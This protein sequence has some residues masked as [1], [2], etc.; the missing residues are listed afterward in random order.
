[1]R[2]SLPL[3][4]LALAVLQGCATTP[5]AAEGFWVS[6]TA[7][8]GVEADMPDSLEGLGEKADLV[9]TGRIV[10]YAEGRDYTDPGR[11][12]NR[13]GNVV[14]EIAKSHPSTAAASGRVR[15]EFTRAP[16]V[17]AA[18]ASAQLP[19]EELVFFL[20]D[21]YEDAEGPVYRCTSPAL[22]VLGVDKGSPSSKREPAASE[23]LRLGRARGSYATVADVYAEAVA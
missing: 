22:C 10:G 17:S 6:H 7:A 11:A 9:V 4:A 18:E 20:T 14:V 8:V 12:P 21:Y 2:R 16:L 1:M 13:T 15:V 19:A 3:I 23:R 5:A